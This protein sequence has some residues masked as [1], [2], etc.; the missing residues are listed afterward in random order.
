MTRLLI[1]GEDLLAKLPCEDKET[2]KSTLI[3][4]LPRDVSGAFSVSTVGEV[5]RNV[6]ESDIWD[7]P[8]T[9]INFHVTDNECCCGISDKG[10]SMLAFEKRAGDIDP[11]DICLKYP[12]SFVTAYEDRIQ[13][14]F[15]LYRFIPG[16]MSERSMHYLEAVI[17][18]LEDALYARSVS[19]IFN[20]CSPKVTA[21]ISTHQFK[22][23]FDL[24]DLFRIADDA[25]S[26]G[27]IEKILNRQNYI[28]DAKASGGK[29]A[30]AIRKSKS[31]D[32][33]NKAIAEIF[34]RSERVTQ[35]T[36]AKYSGL[37]RKTVNKNWSGRAV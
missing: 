24:N 30:A 14:V 37:S 22:S 16:T 31:I 2:F 3:K 18:E 23:R 26:M 35:G 21:W 9:Q 27:S 11:Y 6:P 28:K 36:V 25:G 32:A 33:I 17:N 34:S 1:E 12:P 8:I 20:P 19:D 7:Y 10:I 5:F 13:F 15:V 4:Y 29:I